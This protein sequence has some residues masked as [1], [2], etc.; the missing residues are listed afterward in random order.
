[1]V[2]ELVGGAFLGAVF[3]VLLD[4][5]ASP[6]I[7]SFLKGKKL[8]NKLLKKLKLILLSVHGVL[9]DA[10]GKQIT[11]V[12]VKEWL[13][14][15]KDAAYEAD[16]LLDGIYTRAKYGAGEVRN[17]DSTSWSSY[18][19]ELEENMEEIID[20]LDFIAKQKDVLGL[21]GG[22]G[23]KLTQKTPT[24]SLVEGSNIYGRDDDKEVMIKLLLDV[25]SGDN[26]IGVI[27]I[28]GMAGIGKTTLAQLVYNDDRVKENFDLNAWVCVSEEFDI[29]K[30][31]E[32]VLEILTMCSYGIRDLNSLQVEL[33]KRL[34]GKKYLFVLD[35]M[36]NENYDDW[37]ILRNL[38]Q[39]G[40]HGSKIIVTTRSER[41]ASIMQTIPSYHLGYLSDEDC[42][43]LF[44]KHAF[45]YRNS[46]TYP[47]L[48]EMGKKIAKKCK[49]LPL[50][51]K[52]LGGLL[53][54]KSNVKE[55][56]NILN[57]DIW[58]LS[59]R[60]S[61]ILPA[62]RL[63]YYYLPS[64]LKR[65]FAYC[66][67]FPKGYE[68]DKEELILLWMAENL[69]R[70]PKRNSRLEEV[71]E[72]Y[73]HELVSRSF[74]QQSRHNESLFVMHDLIND[75]AQY[76]SG[77]F[78]IRLENNS[79]EDAEER[80]RHLSQIIACRYPTIN[81][82]AFHK[83]N[84]L[85][86]FLQLSLVDPPICLFNKV[87]CD[88]LTKLGCLRVL[89]LVGA[90][91]SVNELLL[92]IGRLRHLR[93]LD[94]SQTQIKKLPGSICALHNLQTLKA[95][96]CPNLIELPRNMH[97]LV[98]LRYLD[99]T[100]ARLEGMPL[101]MSKLRSLQKLSNFVVGK[102][103]ASS[104]GE[105]GEL[106]HLRG[107]LQIQNI[108][109]V[110]DPK[111]AMKASFKDKKNLEKLILDWGQAADTDNSQHEKT[112]LDKLQPHTNL[113]A[114]EIVH[115]TGTQFPTWLGDRSFFRL[116]CLSLKHCKYC[117]I[118]PPLGQLP[119]LKE[120]HISKFKGLVSIGPEFYG[121]GCCAG[122]QHFP[123]LEILTFY[124]MP[125]WE[126]WIHEVDHE[127]CKPFPCLRELHLE[128]CPQ[129]S[130]DLPSFLPSLTNLT[131]RYCKQLVTSLP[132]APSMHALHIDN[133]WK[134]EIL[135]QLNGCH[136][137]LE[138]L[139]IH[140]SCHSLKSFP[141]DFFPNL[142]SLVIWGCENLESLTASV[143]QREGPLELL[144]SLNSLC[145]W[146]CPNFVTFPDGGLP[147][148]N[149]TSL[150]V[151][152]CNKLRSLP[153]G[154][155]NLLPSLKELQ[156][157]SCPEIESLPN[158]GLPINLKSLK[159]R[160]CDKLISHR[161]DWNMSC[162]T[163]LELFSVEGKCEDVQSF[164]EE[165]LLP[166]TL[167]QLEIQGLLNLKTLDTKG[168]QHLTSLKKLQ[169]LDC[170]KLESIGEEGMLPS[171]AVDL[172]VWK[173]PL[174]QEQQERENKPKISGN[175]GIWICDQ[176]IEVDEQHD[177]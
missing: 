74:F 72:E 176:Y 16:D 15:L 139:E 123:S 142:K 39:Y 102:E 1:M 85:R 70:E 130:G 68:F 149:L 54:S 59:D 127:G 161:L 99:I 28:V 109:H 122:N 94:V 104:I 4:R 173:C 91:G 5:I 45:D 135:Q 141:L 78:C 52:T 144:T 128:E 86:T 148:P 62:L 158:G 155:H 63:S 88:L 75:L 9:D 64:H 83:A 65:C 143:P 177:L 77:K 146:R 129:L 73:F 25:E 147:T 118:L 31:T 90:R 61:N 23:V 168:L 174:L 172:D 27:P 50:A 35:D 69:L 151:R 32:T 96:R 164:P 48:E 26:K 160:D 6:E 162:L 132:R 11:N 58:E 156:V 21:M 126:K 33:K 152:Y 41:V 13:D 2:L 133:C 169:I 95:A 80:T 153:E 112:I 53:R 71:G 114:L 8:N 113:E 100:G 60:K 44:A 93:Y 106:S 87:P 107:S 10:E 105:L 137:S 76:V 30:I 121:V 46:G 157:W 43:I 84:G 3:N 119:S 24:T 136:Q 110:V 163:S 51:A 115:Y 101:H 117:H 159:I 150:K 22:V 37:D 79:N 125:A 175:P 131:M 17:F 36:W 92:F 116:V 38:F 120:L 14:E 103:R 165:G 66:S 124:S 55:W 111:D 170:C 145:I 134:V 57:S 18:E 140:N 97:C 166:S 47:I 82:E 34:M 19:K 12:A 108:K 67:I 56:D 42:W 171:S 98:N 154:M 29:F 40:A 81:F 20:K 167:T 49:G 138:S 7:V 89:S